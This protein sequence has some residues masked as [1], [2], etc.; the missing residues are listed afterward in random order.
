MILSQGLSLAQVWVSGQV[1]VI[2]EVWVI[3]LGL[4]MGLINDINEVWLVILRI[5]YGSSFDFG[6]T[7]HFGQVLILGQ[8]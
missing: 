7:F 1:Y 5:F 8:C 3:V 6:S 2:Y 4:F